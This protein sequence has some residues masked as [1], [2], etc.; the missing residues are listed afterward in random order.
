MRITILLLVVALSFVATGCQDNSRWTRVRSPDGKM[1]ARVQTVE[2]GPMGIGDFGTTVDLNWTRGSQQAAVV[3][4]VNNG[5]GGPGGLDV[6][7]QWL[8][9][10][11]LEIVYKHGQTIDLQA[12]TCHGI[13]ISAREMRSTQ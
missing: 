12:I 3:F 2:P 11:H 6:A 10:T 9:P 7:V 5:P 13:E 4:A 1:I 8:N